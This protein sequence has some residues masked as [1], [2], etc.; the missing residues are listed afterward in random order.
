MPPVEP[1]P[2]DPATYAKSAAIYDA[3]YGFKDYAHEASLLHRLIQRHK[4][5]PGTTLLDVA[6][7]TGGH[8]A[9]LQADY[10]AE[11]L[12]LDQAMLE[13]AQSRLPQ[14]R[15]HH[16]DM[17]H[18][19]LGRPFDVVTCLFSAIGYVR[20]EAAMSQAVANMAR[21][22][23][24]GGVLL[25]EPWFTPETFHPGSLHALFVDQ[26]DLKIARM[27]LSHVEDS[28]SVLDFHYMVG[29]PDGIR[30]FTE[31]HELGLLTPEQVRRA[32]EAAGLDTYHDRDGLTGRGLWIGVRADTARAA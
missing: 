18:F 20:S 25:V 30:T 31:R 29:T 12:D 23:S 13:V 17:T 11:G 8:L 7:G 1:E 3:E 4:R 19:D 16:G 28:L 26:P 14:I 22:L 24:P 15:F 21:H 32:F 2:H 5:S 10:Q 6:C 27:N 9:F